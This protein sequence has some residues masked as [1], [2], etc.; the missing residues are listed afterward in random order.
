MKKHGILNSHLAKLADDLGHTDRV[1]IGDLGLPVPDGV[2]KIDLSLKPG[3][4]NFQDVLA[5]YLEH[6]LVE[7]V[8]LAE[9]IKSQN[10]KQLEDLLARL[11]SSVIVEY[12]SHEELK[13]L[14]KSTKAV[15][16]TGENTPYSNVILQSGVTI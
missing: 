16:R 8:I 12:V 1:C 3:Q 9:E 13:A 14:T 15:V 5:V 7:K 11:D 4:P 2:A 10:P 6:V